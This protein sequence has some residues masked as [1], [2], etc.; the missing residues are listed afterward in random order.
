MHPARRY[1]YWLGG[2]DHFAAD[3]ESGD[4][5]AEG[6]P[7]VRIAALENRAFMRR[8]VT[9]LTR[10]A[11][12]RQFLD[13]GTGIPAPN[14]T[15]EIAQAIAP[16][17]RV[18]Y[19]DN[20]PIVL[21][22]ARALLNSK[23]EGATAYI[24]ADVRDYE[25]ILS[26]PTLRQTLDFSQPIGLMMIAIL[27]FLR[28][29]DD[30]YKVVSQLANALPVGSYIAATHTTYDFFPPAIMKLVSNGPEGSGGVILR[31]REDIVRF[32]D[33]MDLVEPG[34]VPPAEWHPDVPEAERPTP[35]DTVSYGGVAKI[36]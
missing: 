17:S 36:P 24:E 25:R 33:G 3:R 26:D 11:G 8:A 28:D 32:F 27:H 14:N 23:A 7:S 19:V 5:I 9:F 16:G 20:D 35:A 22:H 34:V 6:F 18:V 10:E 2:K 31:T 1:N 12:I 30:P 29:S 21:S 13:V 4:S 15:H